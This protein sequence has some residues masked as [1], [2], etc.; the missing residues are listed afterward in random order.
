MTASPPPPPGP[1]SSPRRPL[2]FD[3]FIAILV[4]FGAVGAILFWSLSRGNQ[5]SNWLSSQPL[6]ALPRVAAPVPD[7][8]TAAPA[9]PPPAALPGRVAPQPD[10]TPAP[11]AAPNTTRFVPFGPVPAPTAQPSATPELVGSFSDVPPDF[12]AFPFI[13]ALSQ[14]DIING[15]PNGTFQPNKPVTRAEFAAMVQKAF[16]Q[17]PNRNVAKFN[18]IPTNYWAAPAIEETYRTQFLSGYPQN[19]FRPDQEIPRVQAL[20]AL[21]SGLNLKP[22][23]SASK[24]AQFYQDAE[25]IPD[26]AT[27]KVAAA[28]EAGLVVN[29]PAEKFLN[30][31]QVA[32]RSDVAAFIYQALVKTGK[33]EPVDSKYVVEPPQPQ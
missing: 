5:G 27:D 24:A 7:L 12:W 8:G 22:Q 9:S 4:A 33:A 30:P 32:T 13:Q 15:F 1:P 17:K 26:Y 10:A 16:N 25:Q 21:A 3:E 11:Q 28:T 18:D 2:G 31:T 23:S 20:V 29:Y 19:R 6:E 14:R